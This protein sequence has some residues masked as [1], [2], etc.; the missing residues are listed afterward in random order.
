[1]KKLLALPALALSALLPISCLFEDSSRISATV[2]AI[3]SGTSEYRY[4]LLTV[5]EGG[6]AECLSDSSL[7]DSSTDSPSPRYKEASLI[8]F[9]T[10]VVD[11]EDLG[12][13]NHAGAGTN[14]RDVF[15]TPYVADIHITGITGTTV[16]GHFLLRDSAG[17]VQ[18]KKLAFRA[19]KCP[20]YASGS[21]LARSATP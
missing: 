18:K 19:V 13:G 5:M 20:D 11:L 7:F 16:S 12:I 2:Q 3:G 1:M 8:Q 4:V 10:T 6:E 21:G 15:Y 14:S 9:D 17:V